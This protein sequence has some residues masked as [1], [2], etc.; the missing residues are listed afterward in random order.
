MDPSDWISL[1][2]LIVALGFGVLNL[3]YT[4]RTFEASVYPL[5]EISLVPHDNT[6][7]A[8]GNLVSQEMR[9]SIT[10]RNHSANVAIAETSYF[11]NVLDPTRGWRFWHKKWLHYDSG[12]GSSINPTSKAEIQTLG[13]VEHFL[14]E[15]VTHLIRKVQI[16]ATRER[17]TYYYTLAQIHPLKV[18]LSVNYKPG[19]SGARV[20]RVSRAYTLSPRH[21]PIRGESKMIRWDLKL[22]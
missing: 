2:A 5:L 6:I 16:P 4:K 9:F 15:R 12:V 22:L 11:I 20:L 14:E 19:I 1:V 3:L 10:L 8:F 7:G 13:S 17:T 18:L 21:E